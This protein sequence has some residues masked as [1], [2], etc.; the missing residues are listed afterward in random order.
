[1]SISVSVADNTGEI[2]RELAER[3]DI[4]LE[5]IG[6]QAEGYAVAAIESTPRRVDTGLLRNSITHGLSGESPAK[7]TYYSDDGTK[8]GSYSGAFPGGEKAVY[9]GTNVAYAGYVHD[10]TS[11]MDPN[12]FLA[13]AASGHGDDYRKIMERSLKDV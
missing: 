3:I 8:S 11:K 12:R 6:V 2:L 4:G 9:I 10:G 13:S 5:E 7:G 1:M